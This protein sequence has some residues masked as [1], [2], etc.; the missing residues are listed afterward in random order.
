MKKF[1]LTPNIP[2]FQQTQTH[3]N[4]SICIT[5]FISLRCVRELFLPYFDVATICDIIL[6]SDQQ[7]AETQTLIQ[8]ENRATKVVKKM[9]VL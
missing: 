2:L 6:G 3:P 5:I 7:N 4:N 9:D 8:V 1:L